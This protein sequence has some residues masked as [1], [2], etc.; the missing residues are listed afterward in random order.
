M[1]A[2]SGG[3][4]FY[5][6]GGRHATE[7]TGMTGATPTWES[8]AFAPA[9]SV[10]PPMPGHAPLPSHAFAPAPSLVPT[11][12]VPAGVPVLAPPPLTPAATPAVAPG[13]PTGPGVP[14]VVRGVRA[15]GRGSL[16]GDIAVTVGGIGLGAALG[17]GVAS[18]K[19]G[20]ALPGGT[21]LALG[22][23]TALAGTYLCLV[24][25][26]LI[27][28]LP[29]L[30]REVGHDRMLKLHRQVAPY[31][32]VLIAAHVVFT[33]ISY[34]QAEERSFVG[35][36]VQIV[37]HSA[38][39]MPAAAAFVMMMGLG[40]IS[41]R[42]IRQRMRYETWWVAHLYFYLAVALSFMHQ[43][44]L[45]QMFVAHPVQKWFW[46]A[47]YVAVFGS[48]LVC[49]FGIPLA[50]SRR[51][52]LHVVSVVPEAHGVVSVYVGGRDLDLLRARGGQFFQWRF[53][54]RHWWWQAHPYSLSASPNDS[55]LRVTVKDLGDQSASLLRELKPGTRVLA[56][57]PYGV[58]TAAAR[59]GE[60]VTM[61]AAGVGIT[62]I[63]AVLDDMPSSTDV[64]LVYRVSQV[65]G[66]PLRSEIDALAA[67]HGWRVHYLEGSRT[68]FPLGPELLV[69]VAP[70]I[71][72]SDVYV[73]G[74]DS[75]THDIVAAAKRLG[76]PDKRIHHEAFS[77]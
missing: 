75:F 37:L 66:A 40:V 1:S 11:L 54:T 33:T 14:Q 17:I 7:S 71:S 15:R 8:A 48:I 25:L 21:M 72:R 50:T 3:D 36:L 28:R 22:T 49:R 16:R 44:V 61:F 70:G 10:A 58:F 26:L 64:T 5:P 47:L 76:V 18:V 24:L 27:S 13:H 23:L 35:Q 52:E 46:T 12:P 4:T 60:R 53:M 34:G 74:P 57:G 69:N 62:P 59:H 20:L 55:W 30:E 2:Q 45:G 51:H 41:Y 29:W 38:W 63:R 42:K 68:Q 31:S 65:Q 6:G 77:F 32:L 9:P 67:E 56:E 19:D 73:C 43:I 39:M